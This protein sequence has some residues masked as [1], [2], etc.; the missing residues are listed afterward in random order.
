MKVA[1]A[2]TLTTFA[3]L[4][5]STAQMQELHLMVMLIGV[6]QLTHWAM[7]LTVITFWE[8]WRSPWLVLAR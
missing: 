3:L 1:G 6:W 2:P 7:T 8:S 4:L 5:L